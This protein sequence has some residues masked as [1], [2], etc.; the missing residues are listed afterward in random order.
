MTKLDGRTQAARPRHNSSN[1]LRRPRDRPTSISCRSY[2]VIRLTDPA[3][4][5]SP[6]AAAV[7]ALHRCAARGQAALHRVHRAQGSPAIH[8]A[9]LPTA[10]DEHGF[11]VRRGA[12]AAQ[13]DGYAHYKSFEREV[14]PVLAARSRWASSG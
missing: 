14:L 3:R 1:R 4:D 12:D 6:P 5:A 2:Q 7:E 8:L 9:M 10:A 13:R 11:R